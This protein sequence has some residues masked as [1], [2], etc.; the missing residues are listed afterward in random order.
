MSL[1]Q[2]KKTVFF[3]FLEAVSNSRGRALYVIQGHSVNRVV[4]VFFCF[5][6]LAEANAGIEQVLCECKRL[7]DYLGVYSQVN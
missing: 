3:C 4:I 7:V 5:L 2:I 6:T 1:W